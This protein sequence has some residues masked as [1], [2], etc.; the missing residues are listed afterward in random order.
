MNLQ[1][2]GSERQVV[3]DVQAHFQG[4]GCRSLLRGWSGCA[5]GW[6]LIWLLLVGL[7]VRLALLRGALGRTG[8]TATLL[9]I[10]TLRGGGITAIRTV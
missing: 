6:S 8:V 2:A 5:L 7:L 4:R 3:D 9:L 1:I 10:A